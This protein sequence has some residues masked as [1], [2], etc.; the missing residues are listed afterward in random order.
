M[1]QSFT[2]HA[3]NCIKHNVYCVWTNK[4]IIYYIITL[5]TN[6]HIIIQQ[7]CAI[8]IV[9]SAHHLNHRS[10]SFSTTSRIY[11]CV[12]SHYMT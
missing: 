10:W 5:I 4:I 3:L 11:F 6:L 9:N 2:S 12:S 7:S 8:I 1:Y